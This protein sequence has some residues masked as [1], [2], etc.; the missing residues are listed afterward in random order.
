MGLM[1]LSM[2]GCLS[3]IG[4]FIW[5]TDWVRRLHG[6]VAVACMLAVMGAACF[7]LKRSRGLRTKESV[8]LVRVALD[9]SDIKVGEALVGRFIQRRNQ[10]ADKD[11]LNVD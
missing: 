6:G 8:P 5:R 3:V 2:T 1:A 11:G 7:P 4:T 9:S 10:R